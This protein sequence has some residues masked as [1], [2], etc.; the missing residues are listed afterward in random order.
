MKPTPQLYRGDSA[1]RILTLDAVRGFA[2][3]AILSV[4]ILSFAM[5]DASFL[6]PHL[7]HPQGR[8]DEPLWLISFLFADG[9]FRG[10]FTLLFGASMMLVMDR[11][12]NNGH[13]IA[14]IHGRRMLWLAVIGAGHYLLIWHGDILLSYALMG[15]LLTG[16]HGWRSRQLIGWGAAGLIICALWISWMEA[17]SLP[18]FLDI[19]GLQDH[20][21]ALAKMQVLREADLR[22]L[23]QSLLKDLALFQSSYGEIVAGRVAKFGNNLLSLPIAAMETLPL[24]MIGAGLYRSGFLS[25]DWHQGRYRRM[26]I[27][28]LPLGLGL[29]ALPAAAIIA[30]DFDPLISVAGH[31]GT[32][33]PGRLLLII[34]YAALLILWVQ[35]G[36]LPQLIAR[37]AAAGRMA[38]SNYL[39]SSLVMTSI[40]YGYGLGLFGQVDVIIL[41]GLV[42]IMS[43]IMLIWSPWW[44]ARFHYGPAEWLWRRLA[45]GAPPPFKRG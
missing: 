32:S 22:A 43:M 31:L 39:L 25:G 44:M 45:R 23:D 13:I 36:F 40:F 3:M 42:L 19:L 26:L 35:R 30:S 34:S 33:V 6:S 9:K 14:K 38:L 24:M 16:T 8:W 20:P 37:M 17:G 1:A 5:P 12:A 28:A 11:A 10:L 41:Y 15:T 21:Q 7:H 29:T 27:W 2:V 4:N 18:L